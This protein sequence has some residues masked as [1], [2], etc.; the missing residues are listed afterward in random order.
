MFSY[1]RNNVYTTYPT[2]QNVRVVKM[3][4]IKFRS[5]A[6]NIFY[7]YTHFLSLPRKIYWFMIHFYTT[8]YTQKY[9][10]QYI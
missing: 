4:T 3:A 9:K 7:L 10:L 8:H 1:L 6:R 5:L 2:S